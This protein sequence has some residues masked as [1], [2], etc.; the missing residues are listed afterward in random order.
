MEDPF[1]QDAVQCRYSE[2][3]EGAL[4]EDHL[5]NYIDSMALL[6]AGV[7][8]RNYE[9]WPIL[10]VYVWP[11]NF[12]GATY[13]EEIAY[14]KDWIMVRLAWL[15]ENLPGKC[16]PVSTSKEYNEKIQVQPNPAN[17]SIQIF[18]Q[19]SEGIYDALV[20]NMI[21]EKMISTTINAR[22]EINTSAL[23]D[24]TYI[25]T[26]TDVQLQIHRYKFVVVH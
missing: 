5:L 18:I 6:F 14:M 4:S 8:S 2:L 10:G 1:F 9:R 17:E 16:L 13:E 25:L 21:G 15:D 7:E 11:N 19:G 24:G 3:R 22:D 12:I 20:T 26:V 23:P